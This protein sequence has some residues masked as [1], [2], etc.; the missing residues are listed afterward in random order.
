MISHSTQ[1][2]RMNG[3]SPELLHGAQVPSGADTGEKY[4]KLETQGQV[5]LG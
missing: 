2:E 4:D 1:P 5:A 3:L